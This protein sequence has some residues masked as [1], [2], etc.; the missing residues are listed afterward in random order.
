MYTIE[1]HY[2]TGNSYGSED[3][4]EQ[5][6]LQWEDKALARKALQSIKENYELYQE[7]ENSFSRSRNRKEILKDVVRKTWYINA[8]KSEWDER[9]PG[10]GICAAQM[11]NGD[12][13]NLPMF[14]LGYFETLHEAKVICV[15]D[16]EDSIKFN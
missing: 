9:D 12:W 7:N 8:I 1:I 5:I 13:R 4:V 2:R 11:D 15:G 16:D 3:C 10:F 14:W 6:G